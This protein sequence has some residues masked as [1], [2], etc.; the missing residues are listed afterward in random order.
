MNMEIVQQFNK[1][2]ETQILSK[3]LFKILTSM[4]WVLPLA[5]W[6]Y[7]NIVPLY[8][9]RTSKKLYENFYCLLSSVCND[10]LYYK[11]MAVRVE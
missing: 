4:V 5:V 6:P 1:W 9:A 11:L 7:A 8:P 10:S 3:R 2:E